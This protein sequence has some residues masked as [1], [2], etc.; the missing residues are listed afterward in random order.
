M[1]S[2]V[3]IKL[4]YDYYTNKRVTPVFMTEEELLDLCYAEF[5]SRIINEV[6]HLNKIASSLRLTVVEDDLEVDIS[7]DFFNVQ[8]RGMLERGKRIM[9]KAFAFESPGLSIS[10]SLK[11]ETETDNLKHAAPSRARRSLPLSTCSQQVKPSLES[12][13]DEDVRIMLPLERYAKKQQETVRNIEQQLEKK[14]RENSQLRDRLDR[15]SA[16]NQGNLSTCGN[17]HL[18]IGH[19]KKKCEYSPCRSAY[20]CGMLAKHGGEKVFLA[21]LEKDVSRLQRNLA[22]AR[23]DV[24]NAERAAEKVVNSAPKR[25]EDAIVKELPERYITFGHRNW[26]LL[27]RDVA[28]VQKHLQG[29]LP[30]RENVSVILNS[31]VI[32]SSLPLLD[33]NNTPLSYSRLTDHRM[34]SQ[35]RVLSQNYAINFPT[36]RRREKERASCHTST[37]V[38][39]ATSETSCGGGFTISAEEQQDFRLALQLQQ[40]EIDNPE[41]SEQCST[42]T[43][44]INT[45]DSELEKLEFE[46]DAAAAL[47]QLRRKAS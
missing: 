17:C 37:S 44:N 34:S 32:H 35:K 33:L 36:D 31:R 10:H 5:K 26:A 42:N 3:N 1:T 15:A 45:N 47:L 11:S 19:T 46:A 14:R 41:V 4:I 20:S 18:K 40:E 9:V 2:L 23:N 28:I 30:S 21:T 12:N 16:Q 29:K 13:T 6:P 8:I 25:I 27:N 43:K 22:S 24:Q 38:T 7:D 39:A